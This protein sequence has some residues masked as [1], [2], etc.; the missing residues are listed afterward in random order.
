MGKLYE[1]HHGDYKYVSDAGVWYDL[2]DTITTRSKLRPDIMHMMV[3][4]YDLEEFGSYDDLY[5]TLNAW[6]IDADISEHAGYFY[7][8]SYFLDDFDDAVNDTM[9]IMENIAESFEQ[10]NPG[11]VEL[12]NNAPIPSSWDQIV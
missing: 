4:Y 3:S 1:D 11:V 8:S 5:D 10:K 9:D 7:G 2:Q 12:F 6:G